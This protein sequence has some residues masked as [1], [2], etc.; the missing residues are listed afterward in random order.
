MASNGRPEFWIDISGSWW[1]TDYPRFGI[2][3]PVGRFTPKPE[4]G[5]VDSHTT[6]YPTTLRVLPRRDHLLHSVCF[7]AILYRDPGSDWWVLLDYLVGDKFSNSPF[8]TSFAESN[9]ST[10]HVWIRCNFYISYEP[11]CLWKLGG[12]SAKTAMQA[13]SLSLITET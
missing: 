11:S 9:T 4:R 13:D 8:W 2:N 6:N 3:P 12:V 1:L 7:I 5:W 10:E